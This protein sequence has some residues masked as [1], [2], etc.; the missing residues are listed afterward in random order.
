MQYNLLKQVMKT[1]KEK[2]QE[3]FN[4][5]VI[6]HSKDKEVDLNA[7]FNDPK[8]LKRIKDQIE[9]VKLIQTSNN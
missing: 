9:V 1:T 7:F 2:L 4:Q 5:K 3:L 8:I 6:E